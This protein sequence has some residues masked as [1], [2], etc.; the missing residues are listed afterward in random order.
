MKERNSFFHKCNLS[1]QTTKKNTVW[2]HVLLVGYLTRINSLR[3]TIKTSQNAPDD[4]WEKSPD[5]S[6]KNAS[7]L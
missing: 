7:F 5:N 3:L 6:D 1:L 4:P 2:M